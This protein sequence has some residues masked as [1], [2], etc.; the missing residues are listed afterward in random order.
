MGIRSFDVRQPQPFS[1]VTGRGLQKGVDTPRSLGAMSWHA[2][3][4]AMLWPHIIV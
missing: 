3:Q 2:D 4:I 1:A